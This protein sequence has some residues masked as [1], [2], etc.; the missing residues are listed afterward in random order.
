MKFHKTLWLLS[1]LVI[2]M[3]CM[4]SVAASEGNIDG[5]LTSDSSDTN[6][7]ADN[8]MVCLETVNE[9]NSVLSSPQ[10]IIVEEIEDD[11][12]EM[13]QPTRRIRKKKSKIARFFSETDSTK[14]IMGITTLAVILIAL[15]TVIVIIVKDNTTDGGIFTSQFSSIDKEQLAPVSGFEVT[16]TTQNSI[17]FKFIKEINGSN[18]KVE[19]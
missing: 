8:N 17:S 1:F 12:N 5:N 15:I 16:G 3:I 2:A 18:K 9:N 14:L 13:S 10:T 6:L 19:E 7:Q 4:S 11:H